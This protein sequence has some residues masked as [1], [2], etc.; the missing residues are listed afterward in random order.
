MKITGKNG[1]SVE[2]KINGDMVITG[3]VTMVNEDGEGAGGACPT[4]SVSPGNIAGLGIGPQG[5]PG[6]KMKKKKDASDIIMAT[7]RRKIKVK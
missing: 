3:S 5:E 6:R 2:L 7:L 1:A 4:N